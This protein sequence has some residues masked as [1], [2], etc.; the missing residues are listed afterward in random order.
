MDGQTATGNAASTEG[1]RLAAAAAH[2]MSRMDQCSSWVCSSSILFHPYHHCNMT[3]LLDSL[4]SWVRHLRV[5]GKY[6]LARHPKTL[7]YTSFTNYH[8]YTITWPS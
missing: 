4:P 8:H 3:R 2:Q 7:S 1:H 6:I 5:P